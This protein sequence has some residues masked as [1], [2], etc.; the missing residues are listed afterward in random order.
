MRHAES[1]DARASFGPSRRLWGAL[2][3]AAVAAT[4]L[5]SRCSGDREALPAHDEVAD[6]RRSGAPTTATTGRAPGSPE[7]AGRA[8]AER[9][10]AAV[11]DESRRGHVTALEVSCRCAATQLPV[12]A[13]ITIADKVWLCVGGRCVVEVPPDTEELFAEASGYAAR[14]LVV[15]RPDPGVTIEL[16]P[17]STC[18]VDVFDSRGAP[19]ANASVELVAP[20]PSRMAPAGGG[21]APPAERHRLAETDAGGSCTIGSSQPVVIRAECKWGSS[22]STAVPVGCES[23]ELVIAPQARATLVVADSTETQCLPGIVELVRTD[24]GVPVP[25]ALAFDSSGQCRPLLEPG[26]YHFR[27]CQFPYVY[28]LADGHGHQPGERADTIHLEPGDQVVLHGLRMPSLPLRLLD[29]VSGNPVTDAT[30]WLESFEN[31]DR[32]G[33]SGWSITSSPH[34]VA[35]NEGYVDAGR[36][37]GGITDEQGRLDVRIA[38]CTD[39][40][41]PS[42]IS[43]TSLT[44]GRPAVLA[45]R[46]GQARSVSVRLAPESVMDLVPVEVFAERGA[47]AAR[48]VGTAATVRDGAELGL[49]WRGGDLE[50]R[51]RLSGGPVLDR[52]DAGA[53]ETTASLT[54]DLRNL[55]RVEVHGVPAECRNVYLS[56]DGRILFTGVRAGDS[57][58][59]ASLADGHYHLGTAASQAAFRRKSA[60][61]SKGEVEVRRGVTNSVRWQDVVHRVGK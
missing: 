9:E 7:A 47:M 26:Q 48:V 28:R 10:R 11:A 53:L 22:L 21:N 33:R 46:R 60:F 31:D 55:G 3:V 38:V 61:G 54:V 19:V 45:L 34:L 57:L 27:P 41:V 37:W 30:M 43:A 15:R 29:Q 24:L 4:A 6:S 59:F 12:E 16:L 17:E 32:V 51:A 58:S 18:R 20:Y 8:T 56:P 39:R 52:I 2:L 14:K 5:V 13:T 25:V 36:L 49:M 44:K 1:D 40:H 50:L 23:L 42:Y 35:T